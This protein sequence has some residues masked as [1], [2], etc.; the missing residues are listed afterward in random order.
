MGSGAPERL[1]RSG[2]PELVRVAPERSAPSRK[3]RPHRNAGAT[4]TTSAQL[5][6]P[7]QKTV[8][9]FQHRRRADECKSKDAHPERRRQQARVRDWP[10]AG[11]V[12]S[13]K[14][15]LVLAKPVQSARAGPRSKHRTLRRIS[16]GQ[17]A[18]SAPLIIGGVA[19][20]PAEGGLV[21]PQSGLDSRGR[22]SPITD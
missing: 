13:G 9:L 4:Q 7:H 1:K 22:R 21:K 5:R 6:C 2:R 17:R 14:P 20:S 11:L 12:A 19:G 8:L 15:A 18:A 10:E 3:R 16:F